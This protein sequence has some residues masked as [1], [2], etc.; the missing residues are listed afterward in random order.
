MNQRAA[1]VVAILVLVSAAPANAVLPPTAYKAARD[2]APLWL[3]VKVS[4]VSTPPT[5][6][7]ICRVTGT[8]VNVLRNRGVA[9]VKPGTKLSFGIH[10]RRP[11]AEIPAGPVLWQQVP[12]LEASK[13]VEVY[14]ELDR[15]SQSFRVPRYQLRI[16]P[17][18][19]GPK[20]P[21]MQRIERQTRACE[22]IVLVEIQS[23][24]PP[25]QVGEA[26]RIVGMVRRV[27]LDRSG[28]GLSRSRPLKFAAPCRWPAMS[29]QGLP[30][31][32]TASELR[33]ARNVWLVVSDLLPDDSWNAIRVLLKE[34]KGL[35]LL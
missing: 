10:C 3:S 31:V 16:T 30:I 32:Y 29:P 28:R 26:C 9:R 24:T 12:Q 33:A 8:V 23:L 11:G 1:F 17:Y 25:R 13:F 20:D 27:I 2:A 7:G 34:P 6:T 15:Q 19:V 22:A 4:S 18:A 21:Q 14:L 35:K 5:P